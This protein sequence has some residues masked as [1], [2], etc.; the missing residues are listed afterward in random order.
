MRDAC[1]WLLEVLAGGGVSVCI[2]CVSAWPILHPTLEAHS[3]W[4]SG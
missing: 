3:T 2:F 1:R 4:G